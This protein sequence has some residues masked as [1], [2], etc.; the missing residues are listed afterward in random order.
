MGEELPT[1]CGHHSSSSGMIGYNFTVT[2][3]VHCHRKQM[4]LW[5][6]KMYYQF[7]RP[8]V[9]LSRYCR[10]FYLRNR[11]PLT[12][13]TGEWPRDMFKGTAEV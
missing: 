11:E 10:T 7:P 12:L 3:L 2:R 9:N 6:L 13:Q 5:K 8:F 1:G 4:T